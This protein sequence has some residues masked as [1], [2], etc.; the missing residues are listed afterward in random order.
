MAWRAQ[1][2]STRSAPT[3]ASARQIAVAQ[4]EQGLQD[5]AGKKLPG[6]T[7]GQ[8]AIRIAAAREFA[9]TAIGL[10]KDG[11]AVSLTIDLNAKTKELSASLSLAGKDGSE[12]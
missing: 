4:I 10:L 12:L 3:P 8:Q 7:P 6:D 1:N 11:G 5:L 9:K 2:R